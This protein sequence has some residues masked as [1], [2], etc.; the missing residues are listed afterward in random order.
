LDRPRKLNRMPHIRFTD[1]SI[2][3]IKAPASSQVEYFELA[4][5]L[6]GFG[7]RLSPSGRRSWVL[8]YRRGRTPRRLT[9]GSYPSLGLADAR[10][11][12]KEALGMV[13]RGDDPAD[14][15]RAQRLAP[16]FGD[17][18]VDYIEH[19][20]KPKKRSW[21]DDD[22]ML[23]RYIPKA[24]F[25]M[26]AAEITR[27]D[28]RGWLDGL[29]I[30]TPI[31][32][33]RLL[34]L[35]R[36]L[37][38][39]GLARDIVEVNPCHGIERPAPEQQRDRVLRTEELRR[40]W[41]AIEGEDSTT[42]AL[43]KLLLLTAQRSG[44]VRPMVWRD[45]DLETGWWVI[46]AERSKNKLAHRVP[47]SPPAVDTLRTLRRE[48]THGEEWVFITASRNGYR[49]TMHKAVVRIRERSGVDFVPHDLRRTAASYMTGFGVS[50]L[51][52]AKILNH[53]E[54]G[55]TAVYDRHSYDHD[56]RTALDAWADVLEELVSQESRPD[57]CA[58]DIGTILQ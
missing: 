41:K 5:K 32:A 15:K 38:N 31:L 40:L 10:A 46:P 37:Y 9:L 26:R 56:K 1:R 50:R 8:L 23:K 42:A 4:G 43:F 18:T 20:A 27:R 6:P 29:A 24:W 30:S 54:R 7:L 17:L 57:E 13:A 36:K 47:L 55:V 51:V 2:R 58:D 14:A 35:L 44:E 3:A 49:V 52:V 28:V 11:K 48:A 16:T 21:R 53:V 25:R 33:N 12:A 34:A 19:H 22:R 45:L 39:F